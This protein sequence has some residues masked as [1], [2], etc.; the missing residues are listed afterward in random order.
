MFMFPDLKSFLD[1]NE[2]EN[3]KKRQDKPGSQSVFL[4]GFPRKN[5]F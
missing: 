5:S 1:E 4:T 3:E 2:N